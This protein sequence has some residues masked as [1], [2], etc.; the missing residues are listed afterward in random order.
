[1]VLFWFL[2]I[3]VLWAGYLV[4]EGFDFGVGMVAPLLTRDDADRARLLSTIGPLWDGNEV[5][6]ITAGGATFAAFP[7]WYATLFSGF[8]VPFALLLLGLIVRALG[9]EYRHHL[10]TARRRRRVDAGVALGSLAAAF[11]LGVTVSD[12]VR[13]LRLAGTATDLTGVRVVDPLWQLLSPYALLGGLT[14]VALFSFHGL[15]F[16]RLRTDGHLRGLAVTGSRVAGPVALVLA[17]AWLVTTLVLRG[18]PLAAVLAVAAAVGLVAAVLLARSAREAWAFA[19]SAVTTAL[20]PMVVF[21]CLWPDVLPGRGTAGLTAAAAAS[22][23]HTL[24]IMTGVA[25]ATTPIVLLY[26][27]WTYWV[28]RA[29]LSG[30]PLPVLHA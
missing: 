22:S 1:M 6:L 5:W 28:F 16:L 25:L 7:Q 20:V 4:L 24:H 10:A 19:A 11:L 26:Q 3:A 29:R 18:S 2:T 15:L 13:G 27:G 21:A 30:R 9:L 23:P 14:T 8:Y 17:A 12:W